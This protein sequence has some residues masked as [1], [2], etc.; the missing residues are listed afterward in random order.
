MPYII[1]NQGTPHERICD[2]RYGVNTIGRGLDNSI[3]VEDDARSLS[4]HHAEIQV[5]DKGIF[6]TDLNSSN[7]TLVNQIK[8]AQQKLNHNDLVQFGSVIFRLVD[9]LKSDASSSGSEINAIA[10]PTNA[11]SG[12]SILMRVSPE[13]SRVNMQDLLKQN[14]VS[15]GS[16]LMI[17]E[18]DEAQRTSAKLR[19]LLE[20]SQELSSP[21]AYSALPEKILELLLKIMSVD[22]AVL[23]LVDEKTGNL[24]PKAA[25]FSN[26]NATA[27]L[28]FYS[29][30]IAN[31]VLKQGDAIISDD[32]SGDRRF[33]SSQS[34]IQQSIQAA[35]CAPLKPRDRTIGVLYVDN[36][37]HGHAYH[38]E[39][40]EFL[41]SLA[42]Q[43]A[44]AIENANLYQSMQSEVIRRTKLER[45]FPAAVSQ[46]IE[47][48]WDLNRIIETEVTALFSDISGFTEMTAPMQPRKVLEFLNEYFK[49]MVEDIVFPFGGTL[50]K[51]IADALLAV[52]GSPY[53]RDDDAIMAVNAAIAMQWAMRKLNEDWTEQGRD[54][55]I[56]IHIGLNTGM[57]ASGNIGSENLIQYTNIGDTMNVASR[58]CTAAQAGDVFISESTKVKIESLHLPLEKLDLIKVK[59]KEEP[60]QLYRILWEQI[61]IREL[62]SKTRT[63]FPS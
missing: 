49:V 33:D 32:A 16:V 51:Y 54:L 28:D 52:W 50:E 57:V 9:E 53:Q 21:E 19:V 37:S 34:I 13:K 6:V 36:L 22:R 31:F 55:Q 1:Q 24:E 7:G 17:Q 2:L 4:R 40:L 12:L 59:G 43:A 11:S 29:R 39:D 62:S 63:I 45:F 61:D 26:P 25:K 5:T 8:I 35:M 27:N 20:V 58:I 46:K 14:I 42:N 15:S 56:Q 44:I 3:V 30:K 23:L 47:E 41:S 48:G 38:K 60:L 18:S 10:N